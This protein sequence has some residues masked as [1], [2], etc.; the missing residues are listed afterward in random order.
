VIYA[1]RF[2]EGRLAVPGYISQAGGGH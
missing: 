1:M 2:L